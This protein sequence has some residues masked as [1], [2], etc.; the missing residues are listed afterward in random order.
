MLCFLDLCF[1]DLCFLDLCF[2]D[3][4]PPLLPFLPGDSCASSKCSASL[5]CRPRAMAASQCCSILE[6]WPSV[7]LQCVRVGRDDVDGNDASGDD[8]S[9]GGGGDGGGK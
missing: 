5:S 9:D 4:C 2:L 3:L 8:C 1:L 6:G 7:L